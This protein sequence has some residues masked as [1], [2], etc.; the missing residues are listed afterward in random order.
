LPEPRDRVKKARGAQ[1]DPCHAEIHHAIQHMWSGH[2]DHAWADSNQAQWRTHLIP[3]RQGAYNAG[4]QRRTE[5]LQ[6]SIGAV[7]R[8]D[9]AENG[10]R[11][12]AENDQYYC[13]DMLNAVKNGE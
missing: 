11:R 6:E 13:H 12:S 2:Q 3:H 1:T 10:A 9:A 5:R 4:E 7:M 8:Q